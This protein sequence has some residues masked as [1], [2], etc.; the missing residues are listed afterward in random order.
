MS[1]HKPMRIEALLLDMDGTLVDAF[2]PI[3]RALNQTLREFGLPEMSERDIRRHTGR[4]DCSMRRLF[5][6]RRDEAARRFLQI[7]D[8]DYLD[9]CR[10]MPGA[11]AL[12]DWAMAADLP[13]AIVTSK[14][15]SRAEAQ[16]ARLGWQGDFAA[17][18]GKTD[19]R[20]EKPDPEPVLLACRAVGVSPESAC[21]IGDGVADMQ[22]ADRA[23]ALPLGLRHS[24]SDAELK[25]AGA[26]ACFDSLAEVH[27]WLSREHLKTPA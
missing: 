24:F 9:H 8:Q 13:A 12:L 10:P 17:V 20:K 23:G 5:G 22:A 25:A 2:A 16:L 15:Q 3:V 14:S 19:G 21:M 1:K 4:G 11:R 18:I 7:H 26:H 6:E 27:A